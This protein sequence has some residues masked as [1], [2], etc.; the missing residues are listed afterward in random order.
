MIE[1]TRKIPDGKGKSKDELTYQY[2]QTEKVYLPIVNMRC[3]EGSACVM[4]GERVK[5]GQIIGTRTSPFFEQPIHAT[6]SGTVVGY[7]KK[8]HNSGKLLDCIVI[9]NDH[10]DELDDRCVERTQ[11][12]IDKLTKEDYIQI[13]KENGLVG[14]GGSGF[15]T[16]IKLQPKHPVDTIIV[17]GVECEPFI[18]SDYRLMIDFP[19]RIFEGLIFSMKATGAKRG[20]I[21]IKKKYDKIHEIL[22]SFLDYYR[23]QGY[24]L[25]IIK[26]GNHYPS[27]WELE[28]IR[29]ALGIKIP[30]G[31][32]TSKYGVIAF[33]AAT[34]VSLY[35]AVKLNQPV[36]NRFFTVSGNGIKTPTTFRSRVGTQVKEL[37]ELCGGYSDDTDKV[38]IMGGPMM[39]TSLVR[40]DAITSKTTT[41]LVI[42]NI[43]QR[44][45]EPCIRCASCTYS[46]PT[47]L[48][49]VQIM[50]A[51]KR[52]DKDAVKA[53]NVEKCI[54][55]GLCS[56][57]CTS[58][59][60]LTE[61]MRQGK[62]L[63]K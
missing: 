1:K 42:M 20:V 18:T 39:G 36:F 51:T 12:E 21:A 16:Y 2:T 23:S 61:Y 48:E 33:N 8:F 57:T 11:E 6:V 28:M 32:L 56:Y 14:L 46:C 30:F 52:K 55:C 10:L 25:D 60:H 27:G 35:N 5:M 59:I 26:V 17:N 49:P 24:D 53:L 29:N 44:V 62:K 3:P 38:F 37:I 13:A 47:G 54:E 41:S 34:I 43:E 9:Q 63:A 7:E 22:S 50:N 31:E 40:D 19:D 15:P 4:E 45:E 58:K